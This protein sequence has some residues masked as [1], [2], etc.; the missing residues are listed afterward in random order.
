[1]ELC[2]GLVCVVWGSPFPVLLSFPPPHH[3]VVVNVQWHWKAMSEDVLFAQAGTTLGILL[4]HR[5]QWHSTA[6]ELAEGR[7]RGLQPCCI[8]E[9][10]YVWGTGS[11][12]PPGVVW[13]NI[14]SRDLYWKKKNK[15]KHTN[16]RM[17][18]T[19]KQARG[20]KVKTFSAKACARWWD[21]W[22]QGWVWRFF[23]FVLFFNKQRGGTTTSW[24]RSP[25]LI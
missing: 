20:Q 9:T 14:D 2:G 5:M 17:H 23:C 21:S 3:R 6:Q 7:L 22:A 16:S 12:H 24:I 15:T 13:L 11:V 10:S 19:N 25:Y 18:H 1:M 8:Q 4:C